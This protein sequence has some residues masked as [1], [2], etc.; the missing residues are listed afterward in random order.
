LEQKRLKNGLSPSSSSATSS[1][2][3]SGLSDLLGSYKGK[4][5]QYHAIERPMQIDFF[6]DDNGQVV[7]LWKEG[8]SYKEALVDIRP[9]SSKEWLSSKLP[10]SHCDGKRHCVKAKWMAPSNTGTYWFQ[11]TLDYVDFEGLHS[12]PGDPPKRM[13][14]AKIFTR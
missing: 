11:F 7:G 9:I 10:A 8:T 6:F 2:G 13:S 4:Y 5:V 3:S 12:Q 14:G 1:S